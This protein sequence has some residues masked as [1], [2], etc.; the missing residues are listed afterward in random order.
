MQYQLS[1]PISPYSFRNAALGSYPWPPSPDLAAVCLVLLSEGSPQSG[2]LVPQHEEVSCEKENTGITQKR[3]R[4]VEE[5]G[6]GQGESGANVHGIAHETVGTLDHQPARRIEGRWS[7]SADGCEGEDAP[8]RD[9]STNCPENH[10]RYRLYPNRRRADDA[11]PRQNAGRQV[12]EHEADKER[13]VSHRA[14]K[15]KHVWLGRARSGRGAAPPA[16][17]SSCYAHLTF[18]R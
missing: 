18:E 10:A 13:R 17:G 7:A 9:R 6:G 8:Q 15:N 2:L 4:L 12:D 5:R 1:K 14:D 11:R 16:L 3:P